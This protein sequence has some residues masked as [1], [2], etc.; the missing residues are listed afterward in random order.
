M[1]DTTTVEATPEEETSF[2]EL[3]RLNTQRAATYGMLARLYRK[4]IDDEF[5]TE[6]RGM[7]YP[8]K[9]GNENTDEGYR[10]MAHFLSNVW[11]S[12]S[13]PFSKAVAVR[14]ASVCIN[15]ISRAI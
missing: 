14:L 15:S 2:A 12:S 4:E 11:A 1:T 7:R 9:T 6:L 13:S 5:L 10:L 8:L 3:A